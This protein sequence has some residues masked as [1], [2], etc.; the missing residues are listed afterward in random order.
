MPPALATRSRW[1]ARSWTECIGLITA[2]RLCQRQ[3]IAIRVLDPSDLRTGWRRPYA[4]R[5][6]LEMGIALKHHAFGTERPHDLFK[7][8]HGPA[9]LCVRLRRQGMHL[10]NAQLHTVRVEDNSEL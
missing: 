3:Q 4:K 6:L 7:R 5:V 1:K 9:Q 2:R 10:L 8:N